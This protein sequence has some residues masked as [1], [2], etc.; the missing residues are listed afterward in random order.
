MGRDE[1]SV[2]D[3]K[4][5]VYGIDNLMIADGSVFPRIPTGNTMAPC[6]VVG[7]RAAQILLKEISG[8]VA[9]PAAIETP[10]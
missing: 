3:A 1:W 8:T 10:L 2:V 9:T 6:V 5:K 7:E 4:L